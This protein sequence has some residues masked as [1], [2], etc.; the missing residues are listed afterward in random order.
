MPRK[1]VR[2][3]T[4]SKTE[5][6]YLSQIL[7]RGLDNVELIKLQQAHKNKMIWMQQDPYKFLQIVPS[8]S[9]SKSQQQKQI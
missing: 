4:T 3:R 6:D 7:P 2:D 8:H 9:N 5:L 1:K